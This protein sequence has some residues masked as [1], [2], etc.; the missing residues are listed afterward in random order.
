MF[1]EFLRGT[2]EEQQARQTVAR[3]T[4]Y[5]GTLNKHR[6]A[7]LESSL[8]IAARI[9]RRRLLVA[10]IGGLVTVAAA[11][12]LF[13]NQSKDSLL[14]EKSFTGNYYQGWLQYLEQSLPDYIGVAM[15]QDMIN[16][17][18]Y[19][20]F[21][22]S[23]RLLK[24]A[25]IDYQSIDAL[26]PALNKPLEIRLI[27][28]MFQGAVAAF[29]MTPTII[30][31][32]LPAKFVR[33]SDQGVKTLPLV[34]IASNQ[35]DISLSS[36]LAG[37]SGAMRVLVV[38]KEISHLIYVPEMT[39]K[40]SQEV[41]SQYNVLHDSVLPTKDLLFNNA[42]LGRLNDLGRYCKN[43]RVYVDWAG[44][45]HITPATAR[46]MEQGIL[47]TLDQQLIGAETQ[48]IEQSLSSGLLQ[49]Q[50][51]GIFTWNAGIGPYSPAWQNLMQSIDRLPKLPE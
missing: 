32:D 7:E 26:K 47:T 6:Q 19:S 17:P 28:P 13:V 23:G 42:M 41:D 18:E 35:A 49:E 51:R 2:A 15:A 21:A 10:G 14:V 45:W 44:Y 16:A 33:K 50:E 46:M 20:G 25:M 43:G 3:L 36:Q 39:N 1:R 9:K 5:S 40:I 37:C 27:T 29:E 22:E 4:S 11:L 8:R 24:T 34:D 38:A 30:N 48:V 12:P 31:E